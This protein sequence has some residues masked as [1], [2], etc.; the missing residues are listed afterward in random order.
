[1]IARLSIKQ[2]MIFWNILL[3][4]IFT[5]TLIYLGN[6]SIERLMEEKKHKYV[7]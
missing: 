3:V 6:E 7:I 1:M 4:I 2:K 5:L